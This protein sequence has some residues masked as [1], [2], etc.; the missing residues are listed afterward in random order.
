MFNQNRANNFS[1]VA[2]FIYNDTSIEIEPLQYNIIEYTTPTS[3]LTPTII[4]YGSET[5]TLPGDRIEQ[6]Q[7][8]ILRFIVDEDLKV[9]FNLLA[10]QSDKVGKG[11][12][13]DILNI[14]VMNNMHEVIATGVYN[15]AWIGVISPLRYSTTDN[16]TTVFVE[17]TLNY[18][19]FNLEPIS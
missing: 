8:T 19:R 13:K 5:G 18:L 12:S 4:N 11:Q 3:T 2:N 7:S 14:Q 1:A 15:N 10:M 16:E 17:V 6:E 9:Y